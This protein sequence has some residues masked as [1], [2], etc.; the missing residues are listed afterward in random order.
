MTHR[1]P[2]RFLAP[3]ALLAAVLAV[4]LVV[5]G[6]TGGDDDGGSDRPAE[7]S[8]TAER[9]SASNASKTEDGDGGGAKTTGGSGRKTYRVKPGDTLGSIA[10]ANGLS[11]EELQELNPDVDPQSLT[12]GQS[13]RLRR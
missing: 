10:E 2:G 8:S 12:V 11:I 6:A 13:L 4:L 3:L 9:G 7:S 5:Q 1:S